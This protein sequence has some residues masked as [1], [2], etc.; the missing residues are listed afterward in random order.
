MN[1]SAQHIYERR[2]IYDV[3]ARC[4]LHLIVIEI[5]QAGMK[6]KKAIFVR[7]EIERDPFRDLAATIRVN[8]KS[9]L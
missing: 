2:L 3:I 4:S 7:S 8:P 6:K 5:Y 1:S 9:L